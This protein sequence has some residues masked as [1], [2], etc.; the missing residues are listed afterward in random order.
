MRAFEEALMSALTLFLA[1]LLGATFIA[2]AL[3]MAARGPAFIETSKRLVADPAMVML[4][5]ALRLIAGLAL[6]IGHDVWSGALAIA[7]TLSGWALFLS[8]LLLL[9]ASQQRIQAIFDGMQLERR[10]PAYVGG[11]G[12]LGVYFLIG[13]YVG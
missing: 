10:L 5:G 1:K 2:M 11:L 12:L 7:V 4:G 13:G 6:V 8:G 9:F 3:A